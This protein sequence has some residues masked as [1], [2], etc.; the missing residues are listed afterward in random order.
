MP[1]YV[2]LVRIT[3]EGVKGIKDAPAHVEESKKAFEAA[4]CKM[5]A[6][7]IVMGEYDAVAIVE[8]PSDEVLMTHMAGVVARGEIRTTTLRAFPTEEF[9]EMVKKL[10]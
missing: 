10:P 4:G 7:Y 8:A 2:I 6:H 9:A 3:D 1:M 5:V